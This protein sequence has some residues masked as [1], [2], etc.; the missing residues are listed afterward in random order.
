MPYD[1]GYSH[2]SGAISVSHSKQ[3]KTTHFLEY[4]CIKIYTGM[5][6]TDTC[7]IIVINDNSKVFT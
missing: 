2:G 1:W 7:K 6:A 3:C 4:T 5:Y